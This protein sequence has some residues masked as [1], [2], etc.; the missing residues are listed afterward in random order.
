VNLAM[1]V[2]AT[3]AAKMA[4]VSESQKMINVLK[5]LTVRLV[6]SVVTK[7]NNVNHN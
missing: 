4:Y 1:S 6:F 7:P 2:R 5:M 3:H